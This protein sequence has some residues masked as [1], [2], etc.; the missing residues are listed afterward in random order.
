[1]SRENHV[2]VN[3][4]ETV[5]VNVIKGTMCVNVIETVYVKGKG[6]MCINVTETAYIKGKGSMCLSM[7]QTHIVPFI[8]GKGKRDKTC[9]KVK[10][11]HVP[12]KLI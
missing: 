2:F 8:K 3:G 10:G 4:T 9:V 1:M 5:Y 12:V 6:T 7:E 11:N